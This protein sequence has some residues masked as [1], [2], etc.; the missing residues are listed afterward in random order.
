MDCK[1]N[2]S[3]CVTCD[4]AASWYKSGVTCL[5]KANFLPHQGV[6]TSTN[7]VV[8]CLDF[9]C[10]NCKD[11]HTICLACDTL[12]GYYLHVGVCK[13][14]AMLGSNEG[15][16]TASGTISPCTESGCSDCKADHSVCISLATPQQL[17]LLPIPLTPSP[18]SPP[19]TD[20][21][22][23][24]SPVCGSPGCLSCV[25]NPGICKKCDRQQDY[26]LRGP[27]CVLISSLVAK[28]G[29]N[30]QINTVEPCADSN[31]VNCTN[32]YQICTECDQ[33][34]GY[35]LVNGNCE[36]PKNSQS[37]EPE[38]GFGLFKLMRTSYDSRQLTGT[39]VFD[40]LTTMQLNLS[41]D[42]T[43]SVITIQDEVEQKS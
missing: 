3:A 14:Q 35:I 11:D 4:N 1:A 17:P 39:V 6:L 30:Q 7:T 19:P 42:G 36:L 22:A 32:N 5:N 15:I 24:P 27:N 33:A 2:Y 10:T 21:P 8:N 16:N 13:N 26:I 34:N 43:N 31:C 9:Y 29:I 38:Q 20:P 41:T 23:T 18:P 37:E 28:E 40:T 12:S 25:P